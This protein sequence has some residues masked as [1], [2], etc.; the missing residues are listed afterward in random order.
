M[1]LDRRR[2]LG[3]CLGSA[4]IVGGSRIADAG[5]NVPERL[6]FHL[7]ETAGLRRFGYPV[8]VVLPNHAR[9]HGTTLY[10]LLHQGMVVPAQFRLLEP[11]QREVILAF[12]ASPGP[13]ETTDYTV[14]FGLLAIP[15][16][17]PRRGLS[18]LHEAESFQIRNEP[19]LTYSIPEDLSGLISSI[20]TKDMEYLA[21]H[22]RGLFL[23]DRGSRE[24]TTLK[25]PRQGNDV[26]AAW[27]WEGPISVGLRFTGTV[28]APGGKPLRTTVDLSFVNSKSWIETTWT[29]DDPD[30]RV[31][32]MGFDLSLLIQG[33]PA[34]VDCGA[35]STVYSHL[36][37]GE[38]LAFEGRPAPRSGESGPRWLMEQ[39][40]ASGLK[41]F[42][43]A[44]PTDRAAE[45]WVHVMDS[46]RCSA[47]AVADF[48]RS[49]PDRFTIEAGGRVE[50]ERRFN[51]PAAPDQ[52]RTSKILRFWIHVVPT[53]VQVGAVTSP[54]AML[55]PLLVDWAG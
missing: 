16:A 18:S 32:S 30:D 36:R 13:L 24:R 20:R 52:P 40:G 22:S 21:P 41:P 29:I 46:T 48:A 50:L 26:S 3:H 31:G 55:A 4:A 28:A 11:D 6:T 42:A 23:T 38:V 54:Q 45:G 1:M 12:N 44:T 17:E 10:R 53:P 5:A 35:S 39:G 7:K 49:G 19:Y 15:G 47:I 43:V 14:E 34:L 27:R 37:S 51:V 33:E 2:F 9:E 25:F 8:H